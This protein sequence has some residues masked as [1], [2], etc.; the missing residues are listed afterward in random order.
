M[1]I[2]AAGASGHQ[3]GGPESA[4]QAPCPCP[5]PA[6]TPGL[7]CDGLPGCPTL[8]FPL[9]LFVFL[10]FRAAPVA[11]GSSQARGSNQSYSCQPISQPRQ[12]GIWAASATYAAAHGKNGFLTHGVR[13]ETEPASSWILVGF[14]TPV[15]QWELLA[16]VLELILSLEEGKGN[17]I[18]LEH[19]FCTGPV[20]DALHCLSPSIL[21]GTC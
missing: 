11:Y 3:P 18:S 4:I 15:P 12:R 17:S 1:H 20:P 14:I 21:P 13:P 19:L 10:L 7:C 16:L 2:K 6:D 5:Q 8:D 9:V